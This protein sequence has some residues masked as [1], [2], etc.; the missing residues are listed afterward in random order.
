M[1]SGYHGLFPV[2]GECDLRTV[3]SLCHLKSQTNPDGQEVKAAELRV[4]VCLSSP[5]PNTCVWPRKV[6]QG[7]GFRG[8]EQHAS[9]EALQELSL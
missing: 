6:T 7:H 5:P 8:F 3:D 2:C 1:G 9:Q 4:P